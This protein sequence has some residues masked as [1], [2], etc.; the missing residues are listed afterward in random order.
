M[1]RALYFCR[2]NGSLDKVMTEEL[3]LDLNKMARGKKKM[4]KI[5]G[6]GGGSKM[7]RE[8]VDNCRCVMSGAEKY[9]TQ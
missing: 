2:V 7:R 6:V 9:N 3:T 1:K 8:V 5:L 4:F